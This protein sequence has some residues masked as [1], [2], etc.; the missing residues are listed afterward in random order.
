[1]KL[2]K[3]P[4]NM[5]YWV[6]FRRGI[7]MIKTTGFSLSFI[8]MALFALPARSQAPQPD[9]LDIVTLRPSPGK[10][11]FLYTPQL[12][13]PA[14]LEWGM[15][16]IMHAGM[17]PFVIYNMKADAIDDERATVVGLMALGELGGFIGLFDNYLVGLSIP[18]G[19]VQGN[20]VTDEGLEGDAVAPLAWGDLSLYLRGKFYDEDNLK[21]G[22]E[23][24]INAPTGQFSANYTGEPMPSFEPRVLLTW[25]DNKMMA[26]GMLGALIRLGADQAQFFTDD[27]T[28]GPQF[29]YGA[30]FALR[31]ITDLHVTAEVAGRSGF[32]GAVHDHPVE[33]GFGVNFYLGS[34]LHLQAGANFGLVAGLGT[35][36]ARGLLGVRYAPSFKDTDGDGIPDEVDKCPMQK[37]DIDGF[38]DD[39]GC[40]DRDNDGDGVPDE[41][42]KCPGTDKDKANK[43]LNVAEDLDGFEDDDGCPDFDNDGD[44]IPDKEDQCPNAP[45]DKDKRGCPASLIDSDDDGTPDD[46]DKC[47]KDA[48]PPETMGCPPELADTDGDGVK[49]AVDKCPKDAGDPKL[50]GCPK[51]MV[52]S[53]GDGVFD[54]QDLCPDKKET[55]NGVNDFDGCPDAGRP[56]WSLDT[57]N[58]AGEEQGQIKIE[59]PS[60]KHEWFDKDGHGDALTEEGKKALD[61]VALVM[62]TNKAFKRVLVMV[63]IDKLAKDPEG[64]TGRQAEAVKKYLTDRRVPTARIEV[65]A[66][67]AEMPVYVGKDVKKQKRNRRILFVLPTE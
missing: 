25:G 55:I 59:F 35:P 46:K 52:D 9:K 50:G 67:G 51:S 3:S 5:I 12:T 58:L 7:E 24:K 40:P 17:N 4:W 45:G 6:S 44:G 63:F 57:I 27:F 60:S 62:L 66:L 8:F 28:P 38:E 42:D 31:V 43:F 41:V 11:P 14:H 19:F 61:Q 65:A 13:M 23:L 39:D 36:L 22:A 37:E 16:L 64:V 10:A 18:V 26:T 20:K 53:D 32:S 56:W 47:P 30:G 49:D 2:F 21:L 54:D 1:M 33:G 15:S 48:G 29:V 34:G